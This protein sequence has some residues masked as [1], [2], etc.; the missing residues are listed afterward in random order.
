VPAPRAFW[1]VT[2]ALLFRPLNEDTLIALLNRLLVWK[3]PRTGPLQHWVFRA[4]PLLLAHIISPQ[5]TRK[6]WDALCPI[7]L[8]TVVL[9]WVQQSV[10]RLG[11]QAH[12]LTHTPEGVALGMAT[13]LAQTWNLHTLALW[14]LHRIAEA[15]Q[16]PACLLTEPLTE[17]LHL[18]KLLTLA[19]LKHDWIDNTP[20]GQWPL[21]YWCQRLLPLVPLW[22][23]LQT[24]APLHAACSQPLK[25][26]LQPQQHPNLYTQHVLLLAEGQTEQRLLP[27]LGEALGLPETAWWC[28]PVGGKSQ[29]LGIYAHIKAA[30]ALPVVILLDADA[31]ALHQ[32]LLPQLRPQDRLCVLA[33]GELEDHL[34][35]VWLVN[36]LNRAYDLYPPLPP[37]FFTPDQPRVEQ[38]KALWRER[39]LGVFDKMTLASLLHQTL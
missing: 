12:P 1:H 32:P 8:Q 13:Q 24:H 39:Q 33:D 26:W 5:P 15:R 27:R 22:Q 6:G 25:H 20:N 31:E 38:L 10:E 29:M 37:A 4:M 16:A 11:W 35:P 2:E 23:H 28:L 34:D 14:D 21:Q 17:A 3:C 9:H 36:T 19:E 30:L 7:E 18:K